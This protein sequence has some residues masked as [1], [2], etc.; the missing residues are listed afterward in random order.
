LPPQIFELATG[1]EGGTFSA[2][3]A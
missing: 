3:N 2:P 1:W